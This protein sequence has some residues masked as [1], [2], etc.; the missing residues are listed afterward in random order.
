MIAMRDTLIVGSG[1]ALGAVVRYALTLALAGAVGGMGTLLAINVVGSAI[2]GAAKPG[3]FWGAGVL[4]G[5]TSFATFAYFTGQ[6]SPQGA[7]AYVAATVV[8][9]VGAYLL[10]DAARRRFAVPTASTSTG[11]LPEA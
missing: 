7:L 2:M 5:F 3:L 10:G 4:G 6:L 11:P 8:G 9:C 1:A